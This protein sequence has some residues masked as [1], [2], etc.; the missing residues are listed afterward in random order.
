MT[1]GAEKAEAGQDALNDA[2]RRI[3]PKWM[4]S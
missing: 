3:L 2:A 4:P 1:P